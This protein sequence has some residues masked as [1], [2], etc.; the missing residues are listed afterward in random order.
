MTA[1]TFQIQETGR[2]SIRPS[3]IVLVADLGRIH[4]D[5]SHLIGIVKDNEALDQRVS[6]GL[7]TASDISRVETAL[8]KRLTDLF[9][10]GEAIESWFDCNAERVVDL[11]PLEVRQSSPA[12]PATASSTQ[13][14]KLS[15]NATRYEDFNAAVAEA[16][17]MVE[18][19]EK[20]RQSALS[21][22]RTWS[23]ES[24]KFRSDFPVWIPGWV[25]D[26]IREGSRHWLE[27][28]NA[29]VPTPEPPPVTQI[30]IAAE[31]TS[32]PVKPP[33]FLGKMKEVFA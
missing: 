10:S 16:G 32:A 27:L 28:P 2:Y 18:R 30:P 19:V 17:V 31:V 5:Q 23:V 3:W 9:E 22:R 7:A 12:R 6:H 15:T 13:L 24:M 14:H 29:P 8:G 20:Q 33:G 21:L 11:K 4:G 26:L 1:S 25:K